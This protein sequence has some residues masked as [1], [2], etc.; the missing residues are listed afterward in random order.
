ME[1]RYGG[2]VDNYFTFTLKMNSIKYHSNLKPFMRLKLSLP[3]YQKLQK[4]MR[5]SSYIL[6]REKGAMV[7][8]HIRRSMI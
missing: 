3:S 2:V 6:P 5:A 7:V 8:S 4:P 1:S